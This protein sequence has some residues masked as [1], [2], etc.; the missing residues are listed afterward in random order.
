MS[1]AI[2]KEGVPMTLV[3]FRDKA[4]FVLTTATEAKH[5]KTAERI[6]ELILFG[7]LAG[8]RGK[9]F[10]ATVNI[11]NIDGEVVFGETIEKRNA[12]KASRRIATK[13]KNQIEKNSSANVKTGH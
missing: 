8:R 13:L 3:V 1:A 11:T 4:D 10:D 2:L 5:E 9:S 6:T 12:K 7:W